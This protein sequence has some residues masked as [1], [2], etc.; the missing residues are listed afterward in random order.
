MDQ[1]MKDEFINFVGASCVGKTS[2]IDLIKK[3]ETFKS[4]NIKD[5][6]SRQLLRD[7]KIKPSFDS[8]DN[9]RVLFNSYLRICHSLNPYIADRCLID[10]YTFTRTFPKENKF[11]QEEILRELRLIEVNKS[12][13]GKIFYF[14]IYWDVQSDGERMADSKRRELWDFEIRNLLEL[15]K[16]EYIIIPNISP[17]ERVEFIKTNLNF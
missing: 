12:S 8:I 11:V 2:V 3:D 1:E 13:F 6:I 7:G 17:I 9:Q 16:I 10:V 4:Y 5:S 14:P 15:L